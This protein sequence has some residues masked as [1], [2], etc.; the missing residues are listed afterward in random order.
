[1]GPATFNLGPLKQSG[2]GSSSSNFASSTLNSGSNSQNSVNFVSGNQ[3]R[4]S[5]KTVS[6]IF[7]GNAPEPD[8]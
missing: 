8:I 2:S 4:N 7:I 1:M 6:Q 3:T 5:S